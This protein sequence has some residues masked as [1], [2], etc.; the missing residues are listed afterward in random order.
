MPQRNGD[1][2]LADATNARI[3]QNL[4]N[5]YAQIQNLTSIATTL[6]KEMAAL[7]R[8]SKD[9]AADL[10]SLKD[11]TGKRDEDIRKSLRE[12]VTSVQTTGVNGLK[13]SVLD[14]T[15]SPGPWMGG[16]LLDNKPYN[17]PPFQKSVSLPRIPPVNAIDDLERASSPSPYSIEGAS[18]LSLLEKILREMA[19]KEG[20]D[21]IMSMLSE[22][23]ETTDKTS[24]VHT[25]K[26]DEV[27]ALLKDQSQ[28]RALVIRGDGQHGLSDNPPQL[29]LDFS[30][31]ERGRSPHSNSKSA[32]GAGVANDDML[33][34]LHR[35]K[36]SVTQGGGL[37]GEVKSLVRDLRS[38]VLGMG[39]ELGRK[40][41]SRAL[42]PTGTREIQQHTPHQEIQQMVR[43]SVMELKEQMAHAIRT[44][45]SHV[46]ESG[47]SRGTI[48][49]SD[50]EDAVKNA[51]SDH[52]LRLGQSITTSPGNVDQDA[53]VGAVREAC[54][55]YKP[56]IELQQF[57]LERDEILQCLKEGLEEYQK[58]GANL[59]DSTPTK[60]EILGAVREALQSFT[61]PSTSLD[62]S[63]I[64]DHIAS[65]VQENLAE[66]RATREPPR[67]W[68][69][70]DITREDLIQAV[71]DGLNQFKKEGARE[72]DINRDDLFQAVKAG[73]DA[74]GVSS[75][76]DQVVNSLQDIVEGTR[77]EFKEYAAANGRDTE[78]VLDA[79]KDGLETLR[80]NIES[81]VDRAQDVTGKD[82]ILSELRQGF[83]NLQG[84]L[85]S[86]WTE[87][88]AESSRRSDSSLLEQLQHNMHG[89]R[90]ALSSDHNSQARDLHSQLKNDILDSLNTKAQDARGGG[91]V[92][93]L[94][95]D[96]VDAMKAEFEQLREAIIANTSTQKD[97]VVEA[98]HDSLGNLQGRMDNRDVVGGSNSDVL[99]MLETLRLS[100]SAITHTGSTV[101]R[102][103]ILSLFKESMDALRTQVISDQSE[104]AAETVSIIKEEMER[105]R[106]T[107][108]SS[109]GIRDVPGDKMELLQAIR[110]GLDGLQSQSSRDLGDGGSNEALREIRSEIEELRESI[111]TALVGS[112]GQ[113]SEA[114]I[115]SIQQSLDGFSAQFEL[116]QPH[117]GDVVNIIH[118]RFDGLRGEISKAVDRP[119]D[120]TVSYEILDMLKDGIS[121]LHAGIEGLQSDTSAIKNGEVVLAD[122]NIS[123]DI[124]SST[125]GDGGIEKNDLE[126]LELMLTQLQIKVE[127]IS[128][129]MQSSPQMDAN[130]S[131]SHE[132]LGSI[133]STLNRVNDS[134]DA[135]ASKD[136]GAGITRED[137][138]ALEILLQNTKAKIDDDIIPT[139]EATATRDSIDTVEAVVRL[140]SDAI[141]SLS[142]RLDID[143]ATREDVTTLRSAMESAQVTLTTLLAHADSMDEAGLATRN[144]FDAIANACSVLQEKL[145]DMPTADVVSSKADVEQLTELLYELRRSQEKLNAR[146]ENDIS[147][148]AKA[149]DDRKEEAIALTEQLTNLQTYMEDVKEELRTRMKRGNQDVRALDEILF[150]VEEKIDALPNA[151][152]EIQE[153]AQ[154]VMQEFERTHGT[155]SDLSSTHEERALEMISKHDEIKTAIIDEITQRLEDRVNILIMRHNEHQAVTEQ[156]AKEISDRGSRQDDLMNSSRSI[157]EEMK[158]TVDALGDAV[159]GITPALKEATDRMSDDAKTVFGKVDNISARL[160]SDQAE[161]KLEHEQTRAEVGRSITAVGVLHQDFAGLQPRLLEAFTNLLV[162][163]WT[164]FQDFSHEHS[165]K[166]SEEVRGGF[167]SLPRLEA[168]PVVEKFDDSNLHEKLD[169]L[170]EH[171][172]SGLHHKLDQL[173]GNDDSH[174]HTKL[175][176]ML[177]R[178]ISNDS[179]SPWHEKFDQMQQHMQTM[180]MEISSLSASQ[181]R[182]LVLTNGTGEDVNH[183][184]GT[185]DR[186]QAEQSDLEAK[187][188]NLRDA[189]LSI[190]ADIETL[191]SE[192]DSLAL[193]KMKLSA[194]VSSLETALCIRREELQTMD[195]RADALERRIIN[196]VLDHSRALLLAKAPKS[197][198]NMNLKRLSRNSSQSTASTA[199]P[200]S[201]VSTGID[202]VLTSRQGKRSTGMG[203]KGNSRRI[204]SLNEITNNAPSVRAAGAPRNVTGLVNLKR[205]QSVKHPTARVT[206]WNDQH[207]VED[208]KEN[209]IL[210]DGSDSDGESLGRSSRTGT[211]M[212]DRSSSATATRVSYGGRRTSNGTGPS[213]YSYTG[214]SSYFTGSGSR[215]SSY[216]STIRS[217]VGGG[218]SLGGSIHEDDEDEVAEPERDE[219][220]HGHEAS[221]TGVEGAI[222]VGAT[223][224]EHLEAARKDLVIYPPDNN[225]DSGLGSDLPTTAL[226][227]VVGSDYFMSN[228]R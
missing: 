163:Q 20:H 161:V 72:I 209:S 74:T 206:S 164:K 19:S 154:T 202:M 61:P 145:E 189:K 180:A 211:S 198:S 176:E 101:D 120:M 175:D 55:A 130:F 226:S 116:L 47:H 65:A 144:D 153:L 63:T 147:I 114:V 86:F 122:P 131:A 91:G 36:D 162:D 90:E 106:E 166:V 12:L 96:M 156:A 62:A 125:K 97:E 197:Q 107:T 208:D 81:Y 32:P 60:D 123:R 14:S 193:Q 44:W 140:T 188:S 191:M 204:M 111:S 173:L 146:Y 171:D 98:I 10:I 34:L 57:G 79:M 184:A 24:S 121:K 181:N 186:L 69:P 210:S 99:G 27:T 94:N 135:L 225:Y 100:L 43:Q 179:G 40:V 5:I 192:K 17:S 16:N 143:I 104:A 64:K 59:G 30:G 201:I 3:P 141:E 190:A 13:P 183:I 108:G 227:S 28:S 105:F 8:R 170:L 214:S 128:V 84:N 22:M 75:Y 129:N 152:P 78:Q 160:G 73:L 21:K 80:T 95:E 224:Q 110:D 26:V 169:R 67:T 221:E 87:H 126:K 136:S 58:E 223:P 48:G 77:V 185:I 199:T 25:K 165:E 212:T 15:R 118:E 39:R 103:D 37:T 133:Q 158:L 68:Q 4:D 148:T 33:K 187:V 174:L 102:E 29:D 1:S 194:E 85:Q 139:L 11:A 220:E 200:A 35:I 127:A 112:G 178:G 157:A 45:Q 54:E 205:S 213:E 151:I 132:T 159:T 228:K 70:G 82:E 53:I 218:T 93:E 6:Q 49:A 18:T 52:N 182:D 216:G 46:T 134:V 31:P 215:T 83:D 222:S 138:D 56:E 167:A 207:D 2:P 66:F 142:G 7:S 219:A 51:L 92:D 71:H 50:L 177:S 76:G 195:S 168:P 113:N 109:V 217:M 149:F 119:V 115:S 137:A 9:N 196:G 117:N 155:L 150:G 41:E 172:T 203:E 23:R 38:E 124:Q 88:G 89:L 42:V